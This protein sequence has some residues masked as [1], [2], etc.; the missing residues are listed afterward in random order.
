MSWAGIRMTPDSTGFSRNFS[1]N[2]DRPVSTASSA[3]CLGNWAAEA[4][5]GLSERIRAER[6]G[7]AV[8]RPHVDLDQAALRAERQHGEVGAAPE[9]GH[10][11]ALDL[12]LEPGEATIET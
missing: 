4:T 7:D 6:D 11:H 3:I 9:L 5:Q 8:T 10:H 1:R 12:G 2:K